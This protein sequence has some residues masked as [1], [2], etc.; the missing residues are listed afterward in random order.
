M[1][2]YAMSTS[3]HHKRAKKNTIGVTRRT[4][5]KL[6]HCTSHVLGYPMENKMSFVHYAIKQWECN[7]TIE[8][9]KGLNEDVG[10]HTFIF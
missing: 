6:P 5:A 4:N 8:N 1:F 3:T 9:G 10:T 2:P 7:C